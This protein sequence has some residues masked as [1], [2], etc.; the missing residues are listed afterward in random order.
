[1]IAYQETPEQ[2]TRVEAQALEE[3]A[4][5]MISQFEK[6]N[7]AYGNAFGNQFQK[8]GPIAGLQR[9]AD[10]FSRIEALML[11]AQNGVPDESL[12]DTLMDSACYALMVIYELR[13]KKKLEEEDS[14]VPNRAKQPPKPAKQPWVERMENGE[15]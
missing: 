15:L 5:T 8:Y 4:L 12:E 6:K 7:V 3:L 10:K 2:Q 14:F 9:L 13:R 11:G 1:M